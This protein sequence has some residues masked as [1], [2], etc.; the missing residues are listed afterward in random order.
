MKYSALIPIVYTFITRLNTA[1]EFLYVV[2]TQWIPGVWLVSRLGHFDLPTAAGLYAIGY[3]AFMCVYEIGYLANDTWDANRRPGGRQRF[4][5]AASFA[6]V[7]AFIS[8]RVALWGGISMAFE[9]LTNQNYLLLYAV[10][11]VVFAL[12]NILSQNHLRTA[13]FTQLAFIRYCAPIM[14]SVDWSYFVLI[15]FVCTIFY[16]N[17]RMLAYLDAKDLPSMPGRKSAN[18]GIIQTVLIAP[19]V[20]LVAVVSGETVILELLGYFSVVYGAY[21]LRSRRAPE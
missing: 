11:V 8:L 7:A 1:R 13:T 3:L 10:L 21:A 15:L 5:F 9:Q 18:F 17:F 2:A 16:L 12:H 20:L 6:F 14:F 4:P 19:L